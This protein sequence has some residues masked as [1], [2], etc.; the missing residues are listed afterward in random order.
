MQL[1]IKIIRFD[2][3]QIENLHRIHD[4]LTIFLTSTR[5]NFKNATTEMENDYIDWKKG[6][7]S[8]KSS[9]ILL[10]LRNANLSN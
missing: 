3:M 1:A 8:E 4:C 7:I 6:K 9:R 10:L 5:N 2:E